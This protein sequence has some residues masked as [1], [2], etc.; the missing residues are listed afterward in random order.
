MIGNFKDMLRKAVLLRVEIEPLSQMTVAAAKG[1][2]ID[3]RPLNKD[4]A[5]DAISGMKVMATASP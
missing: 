3:G 1:T 4:A 5:Q 2:T